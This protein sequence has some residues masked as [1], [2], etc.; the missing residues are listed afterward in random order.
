MP[1]N[2]EQFDSFAVYTYEACQDHKGCNEWDFIGYLNAYN[3]ECSLTEFTIYEECIGEILVQYGNQDE[4]ENAGHRWDS[5]DEDTS[6]IFKIYQQI[7]D[8]NNS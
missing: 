3:A 8:Y 6:A 4:C 7:N 5:G 2:L 1:D